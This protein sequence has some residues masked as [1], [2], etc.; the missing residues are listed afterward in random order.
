MSE[1]RRWVKIADFENNIRFC[2]S[3]TA[4]YLNQSSECIFRLLAFEKREN[5][6][7]TVVAVFS[8]GLGSYAS[9]LIQNNKLRSDVV[10][11]YPGGNLSEADIVDINK[12]FLEA[13]FAI[14]KSIGGELASWGI[15]VWTINE[16][17][18]IQFLKLISAREEIDEVSLKAML[19]ETLGSLEKYY[20]DEI[21]RLMEAGKIDEAWGKA[22]ELQKQNYFEVIWA[23]VESFNVGHSQDEVGRLMSMYENIAQNN[24]KYADLALE[25]L[26]VLTGE[27]YSS[28]KDKIVRLEKQMILVMRMKEK[29]N[30][31]VSRLFS[32][33]C[34][35]KFDDKIDIFTAHG[36]I[37]LASLIRSSNE[38][39]L[40]QD[41]SSN[42]GLRLFR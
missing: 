5:G 9:S 17:R 7:F 38:Y 8:C 26:I 35:F 11:S 37:K 14:S 15:E 31:L 20:Q 19:E 16:D 41:Q 13:S 34:D 30:D 29:N 42:T 40:N 1:S 12:P 23:V 21:S 22:L 10:K 6:L 32:E 28:Q 33:L 24:S 4:L 36:L 39:S 2:G 18:V 25:R 3:P 27:Q